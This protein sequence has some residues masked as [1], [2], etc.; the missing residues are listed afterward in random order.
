MSLFLT[1]GYYIG[2]Y[3]PGPTQI[4]IILFSGPMFRICY[5]LPLHE[6]GQIQFNF[7]KVRHV[8]GMYVTCISS[9]ILL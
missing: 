4:A 8:T 5:T 2:N 7:I 1:F 3:S 6:K 9:Y